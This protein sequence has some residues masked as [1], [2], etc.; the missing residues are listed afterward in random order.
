MPGAPLLPDVAAETIIH[1]LQR[2]NAQ[3]E[4]IAKE[5]ET[6]RIIVGEI[7]KLQEAQTKDSDEYPQH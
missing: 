6:I 5:Q 2:I 7:S 4:N 1:E 3:L